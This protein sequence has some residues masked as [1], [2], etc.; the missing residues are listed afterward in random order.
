[1]SNPATE[2]G[3]LIS[4]KLDKADTIEIETSDKETFVLKKSDNVWVLPSLYEYPADKT[5]VAD[6]ISKIQDLK[7][8]WPVAT[9]SD[10]QKRFKVMESEFETKLSFSNDGKA[11][12]VLYLGTSP[13]FKK[14]HVRLADKND[15]FT[16][17]LDASDLTTENTDWMDRN[18]F[19]LEAKD[20]SQFV[21]PQFGLKKVKDKWC[22]RDDSSDIAINQP[23]AISF[24]KRVSRLQVSTVLGVEQ[25]PEYAMDSAPLTIGFTLQSGKTFEYKLAR[26]EQADHYILKASD[27]K[28]YVSIDEF[29]VKEI[30]S[31]EKGALLKQDASKEPTSP[32][33]QTNKTK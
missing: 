20:V 14:Q 31:M 23:V 19:A 30:L 28:F 21:L 7:S 13:S 3:S 25:K 26:P 1:T 5:K 33:A 9:T 32:K 10:A 11:L 29:Y 8:G 2:S 24:F 22:L 16:I 17:G 12:A 18:L 15:I 4:A 6:L 27:R